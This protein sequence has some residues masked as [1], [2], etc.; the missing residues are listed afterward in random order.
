[1]FSQGVTTDSLPTHVVCWRRSCKQRIMGD[2]VKCPN[3]KCPGIYHPA[4]ITRA[5]NRDKTGLTCCASS[6]TTS[7]AGSSAGSQ[8]SL[9]NFDISKYQVELDAKIAEL[10]SKFD[11]TI[12]SLRENFEKTALD[13]KNTCISMNTKLTLTI[14]KHSSDILNIE[15]TLKSN[16][17]DIKR[18]LSKPENNNNS[19]DTVQC[20]ISEWE[21]RQT[22]KKNFMIF[23][24][25]ESTGPSPQEC[26][27]KDREIIDNL[28]SHSGD[29]NV[30]ESAQDIRIMRVGKLVMVNKP[31]P[32]KIICKN[33]NTCNLILQTL[34][35]LKK[36]EDMKVQLARAFFSKDKT[37]M[38]QQNYK[39][40]KLALLEKTENGTRDLCIREVRGRYQVMARRPARTVLAQT[41]TQPSVTMT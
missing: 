13:I 25:D 9:F 39:E 4:C 14:S 19:T 11:F 29:V 18:I 7:S 20:S 6:P 8:E 12:Q 35:N 5:H 33:E 3:D 34:W 37:P 16:S 21:D 10:S 30:I 2:T 31:R 23:N 32:V 24:M 40:A 27:I 22:R 41:D 36:R 28:I 26:L 1:M 15:K 17:D 38:Q